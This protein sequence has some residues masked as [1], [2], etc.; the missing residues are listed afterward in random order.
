MGTVAGSRTWSDG[1]GSTSGTIIR[2]V[3]R[4][5]A[6][7]QNAAGNGSPSS[8]GSG[9][10]SLPRGDGGLG[11]GSG[12]D[13]ARSSTVQMVRGDPLLARVHSTKAVKSSRGQSSDDSVLLAVFR[14]A[15]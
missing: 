15:S 7:S 1:L 10:C 3:A 14:L 8:V 5:S 11:S 2:S 12:V 6:G 13:L 4:L 9:W